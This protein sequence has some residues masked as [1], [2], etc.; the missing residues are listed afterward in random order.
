MEKRENK[1]AK[2]AFGAAIPAAALLLFGAFFV[3]AASIAPATN[4]VSALL[5]AASCVDS[6]CGLSIF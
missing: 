1:F 5:S 3:N 4:L 2:I 6:F